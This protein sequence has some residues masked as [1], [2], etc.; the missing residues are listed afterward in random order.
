MKHDAQE[1]RLDLDSAVVVDK[2]QLP[3]LI[4]EEVYAPACRPYDFGECF[5]RQSRHNPLRRA[6]LCSVARQ[7]QKRSGQPLFNRIEEMVDEV[8]FDADVS[9]QHVCQELFVELGL[10]VQHLEH[11]LLVNHRDGARIHRDSGGDVELLPGETSLPEKVPRL[12]H[13]DDRL[14]APRREHY[15]FH[16]SLLEIHHVGAVGA[17]RE[18][19]G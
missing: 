17:L 14:L 15:E 2:A 1:R 12:K 5:L 6:V 9:L 4:H 3:K 10:R 18:D 8:F 16:G 13:T 7:Q 19:D 11:A